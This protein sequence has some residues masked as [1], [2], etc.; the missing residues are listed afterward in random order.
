MKHFVAFLLAAFLSFGVTL[1]VI[2]TPGCAL[3]TGGAKSLPDFEALPQAEFDAVSANT[4]LIAKVGA[5]RLIRE[6]TVQATTIKAVA[7][8]LEL[9]AGD[10][11]T[12]G[13]PSLITDALRNAGFSDDEVLL[14]FAFAEAALRQYANLGAVGSPLGPHARAMLI[15]VAL[16][17]RGSA[18]VGV[19]L[20]E[21]RAVAPM[22]SGTEHPARLPSTEAR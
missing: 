2:G 12:L 13:G 22:F 8:A 3:F 6:G 19:S 15:A 11:L 17:L 4:A 1:A 9:A 20:E 14:T 21:E 18:E 16:S 7:D 5:A 10:P